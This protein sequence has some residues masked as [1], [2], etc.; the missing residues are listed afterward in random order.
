MA[1]YF[2]AGK[3]G[4]YEIVRMDGADKWEVVQ[5]NIRTYEKAIEACIRWQKRELAN[6]ISLG[7]TQN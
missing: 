1:N 7:K 2:I 6:D 3:Y 4:I 5:T